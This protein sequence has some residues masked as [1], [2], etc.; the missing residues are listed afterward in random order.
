MKADIKAFDFRY[1]NMSEANLLIT[2]NK[3]CLA[4]M[5]DTTKPME[6]TIKAKRKKRSLQANKYC[7]VL[8]EA[9][10]DKIGSGINKNDVYRT[11]I[12]NAANDSMYDLVKLP[13][14]IAKE[15]AAAWEKNGIGCIAVPWSN[16]YEPWIEYR[17]YFG[18]SKYD[19]AMMGRLLDELISEAEN[20]GIDTLTPDEK[21]RMMEWDSP[22]KGKGHSD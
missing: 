10:A 18:S 14:R 12:Q 5:P 4:D 11:A 8:C 1:K 17:F 20:L 16:G 21:A 22:S 2:V 19:T 9:I 13:R 6:L 7:W 3:R 15:M